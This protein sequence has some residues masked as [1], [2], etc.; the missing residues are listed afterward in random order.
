VV[1]DYKSDALEG[2]QA[3]DERARHHAPQVQ[4]YARALARALPREAAPRAELWFLAA[5]EVRTIP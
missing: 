2:P 1:V 5:G 4:A 3:I